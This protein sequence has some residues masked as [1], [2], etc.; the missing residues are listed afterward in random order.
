VGPGDTGRPFGEV[1]PWTAPDEPPSPQKRPFAGDP[2]LVDPTRP[3]PSDLPGWFDPAHRPPPRRSLYPLKSERDRLREQGRTPIGAEPRTAEP[4]PEWFDPSRRPPKKG[5]Q[6]PPPEPL[7]PGMPAVP[8]TPDAPSASGRPV[9]PPSQVPGVFGVDMEGQPPPPAPPAAPNRLKEFTQKYGPQRSE[10]QLQHGDQQYAQGFVDGQ[11][12]LPAAT[13]AEV[14]A[15]HPTWGPHQVTVYVNGMKAGREGNMS[16]IQALGLHHEVDR[17][18][19]TI[20]ERT[21]PPT[22]QV[23]GVRPDAPLP[24]PAPPQPV[25]DV[26]PPPPGAPSVG[27]PKPPRFD[28]EGQATIGGTE[29]T[30]P[31]SGIKAPVA[32]GEKSLADFEAAVARAKKA[33]SQ[34][35]PGGVA[36]TNP[37]TAWRRQYAALQKAE[38]DAQNKLDEAKNQQGMFGPSKAQREADVEAGQ[39]EL[40]G[41]RELEAA[42]EAQ[43]GLGPMPD[44]P[45]PAPEAPK[46]GPRDEVFHNGQKRWVAGGGD[47][48]YGEPTP[49]GHIRIYDPSVPMGHLKTEVVPIKDL[50]PGQTAVERTAE[51]KKWNE[52]LQAK[53]KAERAAER[54]AKKAPPPDDLPPSSAPAVPPKGPKPPDPSGAMRGNQQAA[55]NEWLMDQLEGKLGLLLTQAKSPLSMAPAVRKRLQ[56]LGISPHDAWQATHMEVV[57][58]GVLDRLAAKSAGTKALPPRSAGPDPVAQLAQLRKMR[59]EAAAREDDAY[60]RLKRAWGDDSPLPGGN[61]QIDPEWRAARAEQS[62]LDAAIKRAEKAAAAPRKPFEGKG[63]WGEQEEPDLGN[64]AHVFQIVSRAGKIK[65]GEDLAGE[66]RQVPGHYKSKHGTSIDEIAEGL[67]ERYPYLMGGDRAAVKDKLIDTMTR[68]I[69]KPKMTAAE[70]KRLEEKSWEGQGRSTKM[71]LGEPPRRDIGGETWEDA[72]GAFDLEE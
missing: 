39:G 36:P 40:A 35:V 19:G 46:F 71:D 61:L 63:D 17:L 44:S 67:L 25:S 5:G 1:P 58:P 49:P 29:P 23:P 33:L 32:Q 20:P 3:A 48:F 72:K 4:L 69:K 55:V 15:Q 31:T 18:G 28:P 10:R 45:P 21:K 13:E 14:Q 65:V 26:Q 57:P 38:R 51:H 52:E 24:P 30:M 56:N 42:R 9:L 50:T 37:S 7:P 53:H 47:D 54:K 43:R 70:R 34:H 27:A 12:G 62:R 6:W 68:G 60:N 59:G 22:P 11:K 41:D 16:T 66:L 8:P 64:V 2:S